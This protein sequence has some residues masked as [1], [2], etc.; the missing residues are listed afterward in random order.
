MARDISRIDMTNPK[1]QV[2]KAKTRTQGRFYLCRGLVS[3]VASDIL[4]L[5]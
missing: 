3:R 2:H 1:S 5:G 4:R